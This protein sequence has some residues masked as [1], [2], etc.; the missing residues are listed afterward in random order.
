MLTHTCNITG[1]IDLTFTKPSVN[2]HLVIKMKPMYPGHVKHVLQVAGANTTRGC[3]YVTA[4]DED[5]DIYN[6]EEIE[7]ARCYRVQPARDIIVIS[8][9]PVAEQD[10]STA[11]GN[12][13]RT[14][15][16]RMLIDATKK[17]EYPPTALPPKEHLEKVKGDW[18]A[19]GLPP[20]SPSYEEKVTPIL[21]RS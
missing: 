14:P 7:W 20:L 5:I 19:Y 9:T 16:S 11:E 1:I 13:R 2:L 3:K 21:E 8:G 15:G 6:L 4:V 17:W 10:L 12:W 18:E